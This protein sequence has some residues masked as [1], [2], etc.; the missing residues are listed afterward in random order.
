MKEKLKLALEGI[1][2]LAEMATVFYRAAL[3]AG[4]SEQ[5][6]GIILHV[7]ISVLVFDN[8]NQKDEN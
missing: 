8:P 6:A 4:A 7:Y 3:D 5:E 1:G 2:T